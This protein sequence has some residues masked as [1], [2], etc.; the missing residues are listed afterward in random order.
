MGQ[1]T[2]SLRCV[3]AEEIN[4]GKKLINTGLVARGS[5]ED[6]SNNFK[7]PPACIKESMRLILTLLSS[8]KRSCSAT[9]IKS[10]FLQGKQ[11]ERPV[12]L[13]PHQNF[14]N[15]TLYGNSK[16]LFTAFRMPQGSGI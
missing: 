10:A 8:N 9:D 1:Q 3:I 7:D 15:K 2:R 5:E 14:R 16:P 6:S 11:N 13:I 4:N 12:F